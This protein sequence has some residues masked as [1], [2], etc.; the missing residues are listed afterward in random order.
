MSSC[1]TGKTGCPSPITL[2]PFTN[3]T[4]FTSNSI[5][6]TNPIDNLNNITGIYTCSASSYYDSTTYPFNAFNNDNT[7]WKSN[8]SENYYHFPTD[9]NSDPSLKGNKYSTTPYAST[10]NNNSIRAIS[11]YQGGSGSITENFFTTNIIGSNIKNINGEWLQIQ[12]PTPIVLTSYC[13]FTP[14]DDKLQYFPSKFTI[15]AS[16]DISSTNWSI[17]DSS[18]NTMVSSDNIPSINASNHSLTFSI[19]K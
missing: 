3:N 16:N 18:D 19:N 6:I 17:I 14:F 10:N 8:T 12:F 15:V 5:N 13:I 2:L 9:P 11:T 1:P 7:F 4:V